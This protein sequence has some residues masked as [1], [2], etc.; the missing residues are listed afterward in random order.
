MV[1]LQLLFILQYHLNASVQI[2][3][4]LPYVLL[5]ETTHAQRRLQSKYNEVTP[6]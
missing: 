3:A 6:E 4:R 5:Q 1:L 2:R